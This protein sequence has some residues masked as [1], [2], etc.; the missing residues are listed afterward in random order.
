MS[1]RIQMLNPGQPINAARNAAESVSKAG[2]I[3]FKYQ[4]QL[5]KQE[6]MRLRREQDA[7]A[8]TEHGWRQGEQDRE[9]AKRAFIAD[10]SF[11]AG[12]DLRG[13]SPTT[14]A[15]YDK[16]RQE[17]YTH[18]DSLGDQATEARKIYDE[19]F[20]QVARKLNTREETAAAIKADAIRA[21]LSAAEADGFAAAQTQHLLSRA[22]RLSAE[23]AAAAARNAAMKE[24]QDRMLELYKLDKGLQE[25][26]GN[27]HAT[28]MAAY[29]RSGNNTRG[30]TTSPPSGST[31]TLADP[32]LFKNVEGMSDQYDI[33]FLDKGKTPPNVTTAMAQFNA[34][35]RENGERE[36]TQKE[37]LD[38]LARNAR[39]G[40]LT[41]QNFGTTSV[42]GFMTLME[43]YI[44]NPSTT[45]S[46]RTGSYSGSIYNPA[47]LTPEEKARA[48]AADRAM[49]AIIGTPTYYTPATAEELDRRAVLAAFNHRGATAANET[50]PN[51]Q[52][53]STP[54]NTSRGSVVGS[55]NTPDNTPNRETTTPRPTPNSETTTPRSTPDG[56]AQVTAD[57]QQ[58][59]PRPIQ[60]EVDLE[61]IPLP[62]VLETVPFSME[63]GQL[64]AR[65]YNSLSK[66]QQR[67]LE[68]LLSRAGYPS[69]YEQRFLTYTSDPAKKALAKELQ[70]A[71]KLS[72]ARSYLQGITADSTIANRERLLDQARRTGSFNPLVPF[73]DAQSQLA[74]I[75]TP[76]NRRLADARSRQNPMMQ[77]VNTPEIEA[78][79]NERRQVLNDFYQKNYGTKA[80]YTP[81][82][83]QGIEA[84]FQRFRDYQQQR[85]NQSLEQPPFNVT[86]DLQD[87]EA[88]FQRLRDYQQQRLKQSLERPPFNVTVPR[89][90]P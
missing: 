87:I 4:D 62:A 5:N 57:G 54:N 85:L 41:D 52:T 65:A 12:T 84:N 74:A 31:S 1:Q 8:A 60:S 58:D 56:S 50:S 27:N 89:L 38:M 81:E 42:V 69:P 23:Q 63:E 24:Q 61:P 77:G 15:E 11:D 40:T 59:L 29:V 90:T 49:R 73:V 45:R 14:A 36:I 86:V 51:R 3:L 67:E 66:P 83:L 46:S 43:D 64:A 35:Q 20:P 28:V 72:A 70:D 17:T 6:E 47:S 13:M 19:F 39:Q 71:R 16:T 76:L 2:D 75:E 33:G 21:G 82:E 18:L 26:Y 80:F 53:S 55:R 32:T 9:A 7:R 79:E 78:L 34:M 48:A 44:E 30:D 10:Y 68:T 37:V 22:E 25:S 88:N